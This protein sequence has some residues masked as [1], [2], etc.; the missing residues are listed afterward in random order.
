M[1]EWEGLVSQCADAPDLDELVLRTA[2]D[3]VPV[4]RDGEA[5]DLGVMAREGED[6]DAGLH[7]PQLD[8]LVPGGWGRRGGN[9]VE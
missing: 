7:V 8:R 3:A 1:K 4:G 6:G 2:D 9:G 5:V